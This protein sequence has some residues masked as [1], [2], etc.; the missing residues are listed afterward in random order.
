MSESAVTLGH[1]VSI[2][3]GQKPF[4]CTRGHEWTEGYFNGEYKRITFGAGPAFCYQCFIEFLKANVGIVEESNT[5][6]K[7]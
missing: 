6:T 2:N 4:R 1:G 7:G 3:D 5:N